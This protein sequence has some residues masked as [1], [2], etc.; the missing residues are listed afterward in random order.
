MRDLEFSSSE[1]RGN[2]GPKAPERILGAKV[3]FSILAPKV[4]ILVRNEKM[5]KNAL[6]APRGKKACKR[7]GIWLLLEARNAKNEFWSKFPS[8]SHFW[9][10]NA[11]SALKVQ[12]GQLLSTLAPSRPPSLRHALASS[13]RR[14][15]DV[16]RRLPDVPDVSQTSLQSQPQPQRLASSG[17][18]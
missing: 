17:R 10:Q 16:P 6:F 7:N 11:K 2:G 4:Q 5:N 3:I 15:G 18:G 8:F 1:R 12:N 9:S 13:G 14:P